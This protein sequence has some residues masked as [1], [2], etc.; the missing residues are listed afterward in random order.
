MT[1]AGCTPTLAV[2]IITQRHSQRRTACTHTTAVKSIHMISPLCIR[3]PTST[4][5]WARVQRRPTSAGIRATPRD[6]RRPAPVDLH[7]RTT[8]TRVVAFVVTRGTA[9][10]T[11]S[12]EH[13]QK[14]IRW[15]TAA[16]A[17]AQICT[18]RTYRVARRC[19]HPRCLRMYLR[20][21]QSG[22]RRAG[23]A[24]RTTSSTSTV[25]RAASPGSIRRG[26]RWGRRTSR[27]C[28]G[29]RCF[30]DTGIG[31]GRMHRPMD[32]VVNARTV[33]F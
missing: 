13:T 26:G 31:Y 18:H 23:G 16:T 25:G 5:L 32:I 22:A 27:G 29:I 3:I 20:T 9:M 8:M 21:R 4:A 33:V 28:G 10:R 17:P 7:R 2:P 11:E 30:G 24:E 15:P 1:V 12:C 19:C 14:V 6:T